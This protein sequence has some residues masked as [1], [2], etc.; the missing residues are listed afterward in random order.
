M[1]TQR[2]PIRPLFLAL[3]TA[4]GLLVASWVL[5][6]TDAVEVVGGSM[7]PTLLPGDRLLVESWT[8]ARRA[9]RRGEVVLAADPRSP[10]RELI[11]RVAAVHGAHV[12]LRGDAAAASTDS[13]HFGRLRIHDV[14]WRVG[15]RYWPLRRI[16]ALP[17]PPAPLLLEPPG[18]EPACAAFEALIA[19]DQPDL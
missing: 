11:K 2:G 18:G 8:Y 9:P 7:S 19:G 10:A 3:G 16:G 15:L 14:R 6:R 17:P 12:D 13:R 1:L 4:A 5:R